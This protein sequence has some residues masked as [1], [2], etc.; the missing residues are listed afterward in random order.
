MQS[1]RLW[2][3]QVLL[4]RAAVI[5][6]LWP[7]LPVLPQ[8]GLALGPGRDDMVAMLSLLLVVTGNGEHMCCF[9]CFPYLGIGMPADARPLTSSWICPVLK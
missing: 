3:L 4:P 2:A 1:C 5:C 7:L 6:R 9:L 8:L